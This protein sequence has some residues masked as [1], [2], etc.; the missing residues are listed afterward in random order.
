M[1]RW[2]TSGRG[3][4]PRRR[5]L[6]LLAGL[7]ILFAGLTGVARTGT[8]EQVEQRYGDHPRQ[9]LAAFWRAPAD[10][11]TQP[12][13]VMVHGGHWYEGGPDDLAD[14]AEWYAAHGFAVFSVGHRTTA[15]A[16]WPGPRDDV[17]RAI[18]WI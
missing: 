5:T 6:A 2:D 13:L 8:A 16:A 15:D 18:H 12:G 10:G 17:L 11:V 3:R 9:T 1:T 14:A 7:V 4:L